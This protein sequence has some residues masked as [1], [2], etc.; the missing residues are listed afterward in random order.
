MST[1]EVTALQG[2]LAGEH[3]AVWA[4][5]RAAG[6]LTGSAKQEALQAME[7]HRSARDALADRVA[8][9]GDHP[10]P[11]AAN[12][13]EPFPVTGQKSARR[14][15][16]HVSR[17]LVPWYAQ[18]AAASAPDRRRWPVRRARESAVAAVRWGARPEAFPGT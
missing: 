5:G 9:A 16:A 11:A 17:A 12:Y 7:V 10:T 3:A 13:A 8:A 1:A 2:A 4:A 15:L 14:L 18:L 6:I